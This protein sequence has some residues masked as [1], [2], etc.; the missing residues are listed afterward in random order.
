L[1]LKVSNGE[2]GDEALVVTNP[3]ATDGLDA[4]DSPK[5]TNDNATIPEIYTVADNQEIVINNLSA[6]S[7]GKELALGFRTGTSNV[8]SIKATQASNF[9]PDTKIILRDNL[10]T[11][12]QDITDGTP[13]SFESEVIDTFSRFSILFKSKSGTNGVDKNADANLTM[14]VYKNATNQI[15][16]NCKEALGTQGVV[17]VSNAL[18]QKLMQTSTTGISTAISK[19][20]GS[21]VYFVSVNVAGKNSTKKVIIN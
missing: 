5:M 12:E 17:T 11:S 20:F 18:G 19:S 8:F 13:Y 1:R 21:G 3:N 10:L 16:I 15:I 7:S 14:Y 6:I 4:Y 2:N 9:D